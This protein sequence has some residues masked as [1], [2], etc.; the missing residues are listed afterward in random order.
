MI[1]SVD[2]VTKSFGA[3]VLFKGA[4]LRVSARDRVALVG[5][6]GAGKTT[7]LDII[8]G[9][10]D[11]DEGTVTFA[12]DAVVG[13]LE[14]EAIEMH[15][16]TVLAEALRRMEADCRDPAKPQPRL[17]Q[18]EDAPSPDLAPENKK[19]ALPAPPLEEHVYSVATYDQTLPFYWRRPLNL[20]QFRGELDYGLRHD[21]S[22]WIGSLDEFL[23]RWQR[24]NKAYAVMEPD[25]F[26]SLRSRG[27]PM[28]EITRKRCMQA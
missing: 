26:E 25:T 2:N 24:E 10:Q 20:V 13:Y 19:R 22:A 7:L 4:R 28:R 17:L 21:S 18:K 1:L 23:V 6:N 15:G 12:R 5:P 11:P 9:R 3:R 16:R 14:Q 27:A 8:S